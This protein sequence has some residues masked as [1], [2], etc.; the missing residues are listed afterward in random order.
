MWG[1]ISIPLPG[2]QKS[3]LG[4]AALLTSRNTWL[5]ILSYFSQTFTNYWESLKIP[6]NTS[7]VQYAFLAYLRT[8]GFLRIQLN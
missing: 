1:H 8:Q 4:L 6:V 5:L 3:S 7:T 2:L